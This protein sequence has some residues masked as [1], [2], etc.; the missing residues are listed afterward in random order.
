M[1]WQSGLCE[2]T[3]LCAMPAPTLPR[4]VVRLARIGHAGRCF[5]DNGSRLSETYS[6]FQLARHRFQTLI[7][8]TD[9]GDHCRPRRIAARRH[10]KV[11]S[12][13]RDPL[14]TVSSRSTRI[15]ER[16]NGEGRG[17]LIG[18][19]LSRGGALGERCQAAIIVIPA[20]DRPAHV[21]AI[22][23]REALLG[24]SD[25]GPRWRDEAVPHQPP[26]VRS[27]LL[28]GYRGWLV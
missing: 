6:A 15:P 27:R 17:I 4:P 9:G 1:S 22:T 3:P 23:E 20:C 8:P 2:R 12:S 10:K 25:Q 21:H 28:R 26:S 18:L 24:E 16:W 11:L 5:K 13:S 14:L 7:D 19:M